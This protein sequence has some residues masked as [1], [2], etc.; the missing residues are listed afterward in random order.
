LEA[1]AHGWLEIIAGGMFSGKSEELL[2]RLRRA[3]IAK[4]KIQI[5]KPEVDTRYAA[6]S[7]VS[8]IRSSLPATPIPTQFPGIIIEKL[9]PGTT[10]VGIDEVQFFSP[11]VLGVIDRLLDRDIRVV[12][13]GLNQDSSGVPFG[14]MPLL[15][16][17]ADEVTVLSAICTECGGIATKSQKLVASGS[18]VDVGATDKYAARCRQHFIPTK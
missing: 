3:E 16:A 18:G 8:H 1:F 14:P 7:V 5:F 17:K 6:D 12:C 13:A 2:R 4:R 10:I 15:M 11:L 9:T